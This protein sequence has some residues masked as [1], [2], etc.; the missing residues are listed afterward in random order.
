MLPDGEHIFVDEFGQNICAHYAGGIL[1]GPYI[2]K[3]RGRVVISGYY[4]Q[5]VQNGL[6]RAGHPG[7]TSE[8]HYQD[9][10]SILTR[11]LVNDVPIREHHYDER[12][13]MHGVQRRWYL[14][15]ELRMERHWEHGRVFGTEIH[16]WHDGATR[17]TLEHPA[18][19]SSAHHRKY[20]PDGTPR[21]LGKR[22]DGKRS[23]NWRWYYPTGHIQLEVSFA[24]G[25]ANGHFRLWTI[26]GRI[27]E[28][29]TYERGRMTGDLETIHSGKAGR[30]LRSS[31]STV[32]FGV[33]GQLLTEFHGL[34]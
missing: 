14:T 30:V 27:A 20:H 12:R 1:D 24:E 5:G 19:K 10:K 9:G 33:D 29:T 21:I 23:G 25:I 2:V 8:N 7:H 16:Y 13:R 22:L 26:E 6:W 4:H 32:I 3:K 34:L 11:W 28:S 17:E 18:D 31:Y 15:G